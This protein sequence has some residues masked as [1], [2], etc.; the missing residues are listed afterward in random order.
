MIKIGLKK[1][2]K[3]EKIP[4]CLTKNSGCQKKFLEDKNFKK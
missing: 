4:E 1:F 3:Y 2:K